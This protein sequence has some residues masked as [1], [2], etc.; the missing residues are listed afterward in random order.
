MSKSKGNVVNPD[1]IIQSH[2]ADALRL[3]EMFMG[4]LDAEKP[5]S[6]ESLNGSK[7]FI[8]RVWRMFEF[9]IVKDEV[10]DLRQIYHQTIK[11]VTE[12]YDK[13]AFNTAISQMM[14]FV[15]EVYKKQTI[16]KEM[17]RGFLKLLNPICPHITEELNQEILKQ[18]EELIY[19]D[20]PV[21]N[22]AYLV[23]DEVEMVVQ[24]N[25]KLRARFIVPFDA[26]QEEVKQIAIKHQNVEKHLEGLTVRKIVVIPNKLV[27]IVAN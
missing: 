21:Y 19:S 20:W 14:I 18:N 13:L 26:D 3:Y 15:N 4:P 17:A 22:E 6:T 2:G 12:D 1:E 24:V 5:W 7:K 10:V 11:K 23:V 8:D 16:G 9:E 25:G 27:N